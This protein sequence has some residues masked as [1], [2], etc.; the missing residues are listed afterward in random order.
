LQGGFAFEAKFR[1]FYS[2]FGSIEAEFMPR[3]WGGA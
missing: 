3:S 1:Y 2:D